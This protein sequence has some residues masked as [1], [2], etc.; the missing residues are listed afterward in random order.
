[1]TPVSEPGQTDTPLD[2]RLADPSLSG[3]ITA[4]DGGDLIEVP[5]LFRGR[6]RRQRRAKARNQLA[7]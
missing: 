4:D 6:G 3:G 5:R 7:A 2:E 1:M